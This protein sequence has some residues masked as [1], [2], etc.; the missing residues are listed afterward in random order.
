MIFAVPPDPKSLSLDLFNSDNRFVK[1]LIKP[2][3]EKEED[4]PE[5]LKKKDDSQQGGK[6]KRHKGEEGKMGKKTSKNKE[7]LYGLKGPKDNPDPHLAKKLAEEQAKNAGI[8]GVLKQTEGSHIASIFGRDS[9]LGNDAADVLGG[10][11]G[12][13]IG[14]AY[15][16]GGLGL[17]GT[18]SGGGGT[19]EG[20]I[21]LGNLGT[22]GKGG[23]GGNGSR[24]RP[25]RRRPRRPSRPRAGRHPRSGERSRFAR[26]G[27]HPP[28]HPAPH[29]RG[30]VLLRAGADEE[31]GARRPHHGAVHHRG[32][33][34]GHRVGAPE[35]DHGQR[36]RRELHRPGGSSLGVPEAARRRY[37][38]RVL[39][40]RS[41]ARRRWRVSNEPKPVAQEWCS[42]SP[43][44]C[45]PARASSAARSASRRSSSPTAAPRSS[46]TTSTTRPRR[47]LKQAIQT[48]PSY[49]IAYYNLG[50][51]F[52]KQRKWDKAIESFEQ[53]VQRK[54]DNANYQYDLG[55]A[56]LEAK[57]IDEAEK[58]LQGRDRSRPQ[59]LQGAGGGWAWSTRCST[60]RRRPTT[61]SA[62]PSRPTPRFSKS[63]VAL[64]YLYLDY[65]FNKEA[66]Q[67]FQGCVTAKDDDGECH[68][69]YGLA[70]KNL[71]QYEQATG[72]F[73][74]A[75]DDDP[76]L[77]DA[78]YNCGMA[79]SDWYDEA[80]GNDQK[81]KAREYLQKFV[82]NERQDGR[83]N[84][85]KA[86]N[87]KLYALSGP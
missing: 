36:P 82:A 24:L 64:G 17:V 44:S 61:R 18:G 11:V 62:T 70:L 26:Q 14:E 56:Y 6:G 38:H 71:K 69:G 32:V 67:V 7:G 12:N 79:Y 31:A 16:V 42:P 49:E 5:F 20:T 48:D 45:R 87:D 27:D 74:K 4:I 59:A 46:R 43:A 25:R 63:Y 72:E 66:A 47:T 54:P 2:P 1:F 58:A 29:Q 75:I 23:G 76:E 22:I 65:D 40:V 37:R 10:L 83:P 9:A 60:A 68:N 80:H 78:L 34:S 86:A 85:L 81:D 57:Q 73:K 55:E 51:V 19:G 77:Y 21:G 13:Q 8:L 33:G 50:K 28:H 35:L 53:A 39:S 41:H 3:E 15:G 52:Q 84:Y 30:E